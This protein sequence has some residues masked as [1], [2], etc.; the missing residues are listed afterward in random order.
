M[1]AALG[2]EFSVE[3]LAAVSPLGAAAVQEDLDKLMTAGLVLRKRRLKDPVGIFKHA[4]VRDAAYESLSRGARQKVHARIAGT[5]EERFPEVVK[6][7]PDLLAQHHA[8]AEQK[9]RAVGYAQQAA[10]Q[11]L[12]RSSYSEAIAHAS[13]VVEWAGALGASERVEVELDA[14]GVLTQAMMPFR[15]WADPQVKATVDRSTALLRQLDQQSPH[16]IPTLWSLFAY[17]H[18]ASDRPKAR[19]VAEE[20]VAVAEGIGDPGLRAA[21]ATILGCTLHPEGNIAG[22]RDALERGIGLYDPEKHRDYAARVGLD[23]LVLAKA[24]L[25]HLRWFAGD[26]AAAFE[27]VT[28]AVDWARD[29]GHVPS[30]A[31]GLLY[32]CQV[33]Q[34][35]GDKATVAAMTG[36]VLGLSAKYG[37]PAYEGYAALIH[38]WT[39]G[40]EQQA[41]GILG[42][43]A[44]MGCK[45]CLSYYGSLLA[46]NLAE[47]GNFE[48]A[49]GRIDFTAWRFAA[50]TASTSGSRSFTGGGPC[51]RLADGSRGR[52]GAR[53]VGGSGAAGAT[54]G[55][56]SD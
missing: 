51:C 6:A 30:L 7:R 32:G 37:L 56:V 34:F 5:L 54:A 22:S 24:L 52:G 16:R 38:A 10:Q 3:V 9:D 44:G 47:R 26:S 46:E 55:Y 12:Q 15:G 28:S 33:Y 21:A 17:H 8:A 11:G 36:E 35:A 27:L 4:L 13:N 1:A 39:T 19:A 48:G 29:L 23:T 20:L 14:N 18:T 50:R 53:F 45:L 40:N 43:L 25:A 2:R 42:A 31:L 49:I 41:E